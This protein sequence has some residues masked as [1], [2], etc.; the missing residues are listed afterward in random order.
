MIQQS[1]H[2]DWVYVDWET[3][4]GYQIEFQINSGVLQQRHNWLMPDGSL[5]AEDWIRSAQ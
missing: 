4:K 2:K 3:V 1:W 5:R